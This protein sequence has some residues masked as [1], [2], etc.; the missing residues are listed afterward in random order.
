VDGA[1]D[2]EYDRELAAMPT[3]S[4]AGARTAARASHFLARWQQDVKDTNAI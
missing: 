1:R 3:D 2:R 4:A